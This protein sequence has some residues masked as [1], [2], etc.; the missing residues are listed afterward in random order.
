MVKTVSEQMAHSHTYQRALDDFGI[1]ELLSCIS[2]Y[3]DEDF[4]ASLMNLEEQEVES[5]AAMLIQRL[6]DNLSGKLI[7]N[8][9]NAIRHGDSHVISDPTNLEIP[10]PSIDLPTYFPDHVVPRYQEG[11]RV[12]WRPLTHT[13][14]WGMVMGRFYARNHCQWAVCYLIRLDQESPSA[15]WTVADTAWEEDLEPNT[16]NA[17]GKLGDVSSFPK[18]L[19]TSPGNYH[20][21]REHR[22][23][24]RTLTQRERDA[25]ALYSNCQLGLTPRKFYS[26]W[27]V[28]YEEIAA[29]CSRSSSTVQRWFSR[30][31]NY[32][33]PTSNDLRH[34]AIMDFLLEHLEEIPSTLLNL[35][36]PQKL[37]Q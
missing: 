4:N 3:A 36:C 33:R 35:L 2:N 21:E 11:D 16:H 14:D 31:R 9:L 23:N 27:S 8:Y 29:I 6:T 20:D 28:R 30:G 7:A 17:W 37:S 5:L 25:I 13:T 18:S 19:R 34:L 22:T 26:K 1:T 12:R 15:A 32:K 10:L 24:P